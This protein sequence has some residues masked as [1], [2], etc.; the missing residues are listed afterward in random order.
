MPLPTTSWPEASPPPDGRLA[1]LEIGDYHPAASDEALEL[2][3]EST[4]GSAYRIRFRRETFHRRAE[5]FA[6]HRIRTARLNGRLAGIG[7]VALKDVEIHGKSSRA[8]FLFDLRVRPDVR[9]LGIGRRLG[10][11]LLQWARP[12]SEMAYTY[13]MG[14]NRAATR[15]VLHFGADVGGF[16]YLVRPV[17]L[18]RHSKALLRSASMEEVHAQMRRSG[19]FEFYANPLSEGRTRAHVASWLLPGVGGLSGVSAWSMRGILEE[20]VVSLPPPLRAARAILRSLPSRISR[21]VRLPEDGEALRS[22]Y[23]FD[24]F[25]SSPVAAR[26][27]VRAV[28]E[29]ARE[30]GIDWLY[31]PHTPG[32]PLL[33]AVRADTPRLLSPVVPYRMIAR[34]NDGS[35]SP[36]FR[37]LYVDP[38]D[39]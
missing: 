23:L 1:G 14:D 36:L 22:I 18:R 8:A 20:V 6:V 25:A 32:D 24:F 34:Q 4:Q 35:D 11:D 31:L 2:E 16:A 19:T 26:D 37:R 5:L 27:L 12:R 38:R 29:E 3:M 28:V 39:L 13:T 7:A 15:V 9:G 33:A 10:E 21:R 30:R 17:F